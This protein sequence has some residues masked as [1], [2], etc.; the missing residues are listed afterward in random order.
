VSATSKAEW[1]FDILTK[2]RE[3]VEFPQLDLPKNLPFVKDPRDMSE[4]DV[5]TAARLA[6]RYW[7]LGEGP[8]NHVV[9]LL[10][11]KGFFSTL[12]LLNDNA[13]DAFSFYT[14]FGDPV[15]ILGSDKQCAV[16]ER[17]NAAHELG[18]LL[19]HK[20]VPHALAQVSEIH[21][22][23]ERQATVF[24]AEFLFPTRSF[25]ECFRN[26]KLHDFL[27]AKQY[28]KVSVQLM[29][30]RAKELEV[31][32]EAECKRMFISVAK[33]GWRSSE[34][35]DDSL[36]MEEPALIPDAVTSLIEGG[37]ISKDEF[38]CGFPYHPID[39]ELMCSLPRGY[40]SPV[41]P[42]IRVLNIHAG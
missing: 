6:R 33:R 41:P 24:A 34:P 11:S 38:I 17:S 2:L 32:T 16:R 14:A 19:L 39:V 9:W 40:F 8:I 35:L 10:E 4:E 31:L 5:K 28:W 23:M 1:F 18:H 15:I 3:F 29:I 13:L 21:R 42:S 12:L 26:P 36:P 20:S 27:S 37:Y 25:L 30:M 7:D 22:L